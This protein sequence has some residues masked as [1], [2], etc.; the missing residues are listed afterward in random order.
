M[1]KLELSQRH[2]DKEYIVI[3]QQYVR[4][5]EKENLKLARE[6]IKSNFVLSLEE[7]VSPKAN[8]R[9]LRKEA[10]SIA[11]AK[12]DV[13]N[14]EYQEQAAIEEKIKAPILKAKKEARIA[15]HMA[16]KKSKVSNL[17]SQKGSKGD[18]QVAL[19]LDAFV[20][21]T[22]DTVESTLNSFIESDVKATDK[23]NNKKNEVKSSN[24]LNRFINQSSGNSS[25]TSFVDRDKDKVIDR[26][27]IKDM[28]I[29]NKNNINILYDTNFNEN[30]FNGHLLENISK[31]G[32][33]L[34]KDKK[35]VL[36]EEL[37]LIY[38]R[39]NNISSIYSYK[40][41]LFEVSNTLNGPKMA[42]FF[43]SK[44]DKKISEICKEF[45]LVSNTKYYSDE[46][47]DIYLSGYYRAVNKT[48]IRFIC[49]ASTKEVFF[50]IEN[51]RIGLRECPLARRVSITRNAFRPL[52]SDA[53]LVRLI[54]LVKS[55][56]LKEFSLGHADLS[57]DNA[58]KGKAK[59]NKA[60]NL[61]KMLEGSNSLVSKSEQD[62]AKEA[63]ERE[64]RERELKKLTE[65]SLNSTKE[66]SSI[67]SVDASKD[68]SA[69]KA[70]VEEKTSS[71]K[72]DVDFFKAKV[73]ESRN[74]VANAATDWF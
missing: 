13:R 11:Q 22:E 26:D 72:K 47:N 42:T 21:T 41:V 40:G 43:N 5:L 53:K 55:G 62:S 8:F 38:S 23:S 2:I 49:L 64:Q 30:N 44:D 7:I 6:V 60:A 16:N 46:D 19:N 24:F 61:L 32:L 73:L 10:K 15:E 20:T 3:L 45:G 52:N 18:V 14:K 9:N 1:I 50:F 58:N 48:D 74:R 69:E 25:T 68:N 29:L 34:V 17:D 36:T 63:K 37:S 35:L 31:L 4:S 65:A 71:N 67:I 33:T 12:L 66:D 27:S 28:G 70:E 59:V 57:S 39:A 54:S 56:Q 51:D